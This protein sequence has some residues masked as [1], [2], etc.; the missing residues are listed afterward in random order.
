M[1]IKGLCETCKHGKLYK[2]KLPTDPD[3]DFYECDLGIEVVR[4]HFPLSPPEELGTED[5]PCPEWAISDLSKANARIEEL[6]AEVARLR[7]R[8]YY[9]KNRFYWIARTPIKDL[10]TFEVSGGKGTMTWATVHKMALD[11]WL[12]IT[13]ALDGEGEKPIKVNQLPVGPQQAG[14]YMPHDPDM[15]FNVIPKNEQPKGEEEE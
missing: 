6:Q 7:E 5:C 9:T 13:A 14:H 11:A 1:A 2:D 15:R 8:L 4:K 3:I 12:F 10:T